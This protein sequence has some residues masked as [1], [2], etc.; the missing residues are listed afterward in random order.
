MYEI[1]HEYKKRGI[2]VCFVK[3]RE[4]LL[5]LFSR[6]G[7]MQLVDSHHYQKIRDAVSVLTSQSRSPSAQESPSIASNDEYSAFH[8]QS[9]NSLV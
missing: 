1:V 9:S 8:G 2:Q 5:D 6:A 7:I 4:E 3:I